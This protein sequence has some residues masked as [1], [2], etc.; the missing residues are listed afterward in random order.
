MLSPEITLLYGLRLR[1]VL[2][3]KQCELEV[4]ESQGA[5]TISLD[6]TCELLPD[7]TAARFE[8]N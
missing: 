4:T 2:V 8:M 6:R 5:T 3:L 7:G 1:W